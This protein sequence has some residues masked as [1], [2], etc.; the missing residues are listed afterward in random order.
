MSSYDELEKRVQFL[1]K[2]INCRNLENKILIL[3]Q[4]VQHLKK[5]LQYQLRNK[6]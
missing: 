6:R 2:E 1:E 4:E 3:E 5:A